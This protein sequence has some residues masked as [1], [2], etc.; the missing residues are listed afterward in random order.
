[1]P[2]VTGDPPNKAA[3]APLA[4]ACQPPAS[5]EGDVLYHARG[6]SAALPKAHCPQGIERRQIKI[7]TTLSE[8][9]PIEDYERINA[10]AARCCQ[11]R[12]PEPLT[13]AM[14][15]AYPNNLL[16]RGR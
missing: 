11:A 10:I 5:C 16:C 6:A 4:G 9:L 3:H 1:M 12:Y 7:L 8:A 2:P 14:L 15:T 13:L